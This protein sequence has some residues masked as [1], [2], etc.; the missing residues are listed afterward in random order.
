MSSLR[1]V[2][3]VTGTS[4]AIAETLAANQREKNDAMNHLYGGAVAGF[5]AGLRRKSFLIHSNQPTNCDHP[6]HSISAAIG[7]AAALGVTMGGAELTGGLFGKR[8]T[9][10]STV[11]GRRAFFKQPLPEPVPEQTQS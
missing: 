10:A 3:A 8:W 1:Y 9:S 5:L 2:A 4:Y 11:E 6:V 7:M